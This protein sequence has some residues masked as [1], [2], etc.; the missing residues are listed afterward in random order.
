VSTAAIV[1]A[2]KPTSVGVRLI[3]EKYGNEK[4]FPLPKILLFTGRRCNK[5][6]IMIQ[7]ASILRRIARQGGMGKQAPMGF[8]L[9]SKANT[10]VIHGLIDLY[11]VFR[12]GL[13][14]VRVHCSKH[15][16]DI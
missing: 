2:M 3:D 11:T 6:S 13:I 15:V 12:L 4:P 14:N 7:P 9:H 16:G 1:K 10:Q 8:H 5:R